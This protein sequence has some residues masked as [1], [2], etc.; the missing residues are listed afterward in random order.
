MINITI[1]DSIDYRE[2]YNKL[3]FKTNAL[4]QEVKNLQCRKVYA[5]NRIHMLERSATEWKERCMELQK[6]EANK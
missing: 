1:I 6:R 5:E 3:L 2:K 4:I